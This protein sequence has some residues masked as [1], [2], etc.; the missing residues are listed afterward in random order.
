LP[1]PIEV[2]FA[3]AGTNL[4]GGSAHAE[5]SAGLALI[6]HRMIR[7][8][9]HSANTGLS[10]ERALE[11]LARIQHHRIRIAQGEPVSGVSTISTDQAGVFSALGIK[12][13]PASQQLT[14]L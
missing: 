11:Q 12:K 5:T 4:A 14:L 9:L 6:L 7:E 10:P 1:R 8:R 13:P 2:A 3:S